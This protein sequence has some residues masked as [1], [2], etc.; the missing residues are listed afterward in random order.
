MKYTPPPK[1]ELIKLH[2]NE[3]RSLR[4]ISKFYNVSRPVIER[5]FRF[6]EIEPVNHL[7]RHDMPEKNI[8]YNDHHIDKMTIEEISKKYKTSHIMVKKWLKMYNIPRLY[9]RRKR[10]NFP[11]KDELYYLHKTQKMTLKQISEMFKVSDVLVG[12]W[13]REYGLNVEYKP[14]GTSEPEKELKNILNSFGFNF[15]TTRKILNGK[16]IDLYDANK[17]IGIEY[18]GLNWH[19]EDKV[20]KKYHLNKMTESKQK[21]IQ[22]I[23]IFEDEWLNKKDIVISILKSKLGV[24][25]RIIARKTKCIILD[26]KTSRNFLNCHHLQGAPNNIKHSFGLIHEGNLVA[27][28]TYGMHHRNNKILVLNRLCF[29]KNIVVVGGSEKLFKFSLNYI[30]PPF[31]SWSDKR[32]S[33]GSVYKKLGFSLKESLPADYS[34][35]KSQK[36]FSKQSM[37]KS[38]TNCPS[39]KTEQEWNYINGYKRIWDCG[40]DTWIY[41]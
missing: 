15:I 4:D 32:W 17:K 5:W 27:V 9:I 39:D 18:C 26:S 29:F 3:N 6:Y 36:R 13:F 1:D 11:T 31:I 22:L 38:L 14:S 16:E 23:T 24:S 7:F 20:G 37:K 25:D 33:E 28:L 41:K 8:L 35:I 40:K 21:N 10:K 30:N 34:Y 19:S 12:M 2:L